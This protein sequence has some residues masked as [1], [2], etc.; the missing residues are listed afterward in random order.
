MLR[1][2]ATPA[3]LLRDVIVPA[4]AQMPATYD[5]NRARCMLTAIGFQEGE[6]LLASSKPNLLRRQGA[7]VDQLGPARGFWQFEL[8]GVREVLT[9]YA[10]DD[11]AAMLVNAAKA[12]RE[13][14]AL[15]VFLERPTSD[16]LACQLARL[17]LFTDPA[18]L[19]DTKLGEEAV[20]FGYY[21]RRWR[22]GAASTPEGRAKCARR[23]TQNWR[24]AVEA[25][26]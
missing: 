7:H 1:T 3:S 6:A 8:P 23:W 25:C 16:L 15:H 14:R 26:A 22:P 19:P 10:T 20:A 18:P 21:L 9:H 2:P 17:L 4:L 13:S 24:R 5:S 11:T 12:P